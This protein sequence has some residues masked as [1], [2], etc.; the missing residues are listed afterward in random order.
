ML[1]GGLNVIGIFAIAPA[2][3]LKDSQG[4]L[5]EV[6]HN[7]IFRKSSFSIDLT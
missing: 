4:K 2:K 5:R 6:C 3:M 1:P 7:W